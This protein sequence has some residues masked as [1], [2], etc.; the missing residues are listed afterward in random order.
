MVNCLL[1][2]GA[3]LSTYYLNKLKQIITHFEV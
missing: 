1:C 2:F 3:R